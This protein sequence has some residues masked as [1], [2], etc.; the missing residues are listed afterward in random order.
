MKKIIHCQ[1]RA[2]GFGNK[3]NHILLFIFLFALVSTPF[4]AH[5]HVK[6]EGDSG[7]SKNLP[8]SQNDLLRL[9]TTVYKHMCV[10]CHGE[11]GNGGG[12]AM[13]YLYP[14]PRDFRKGVFKY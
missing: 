12:K 4:T 9:G 10:F 8:Q 7:E 13:A 5:S 3:K 14:W 6:H 11:D 2:L 1:P